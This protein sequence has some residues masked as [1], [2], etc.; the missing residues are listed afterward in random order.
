MVKSIWGKCHLILDLIHL[1]IRFLVLKLRSFAVCFLIFSIYVNSACCWKFWL[2][3]LEFLQANINFCDLSTFLSLFRPMLKV[4]SLFPTYCRFY[5]RHWSIYMRFSLLHARSWNVLK[6]RFVMEL[7]NMF[8]YY[9]CLQQRLF[10]CETYVVHCPGCFQFS[11]CLRTT[12][13]IK[14]RLPR[15]FG[16]NLISSTDNERF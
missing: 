2:V 16:V 10:N 14:M 5:I 1:R 4:V 9:S 13:L 7:F 15:I 3:P 12:L 11:S 8:V 6:T